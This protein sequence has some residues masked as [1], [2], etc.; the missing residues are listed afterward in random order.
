MFLRHAGVMGGSVA[1]PA[2]DPVVFFRPLG[3][4][5]VHLT[6]IHDGYTLTITAGNQL[7]EYYVFDRPTEASYL[8]VFDGNSAHI[9][10]AAQRPL[11]VIG[12]VTVGNYYDAYRTAYADG[13][14]YSGLV[15]G[16]YAYNVGFVRRGFDSYPVAGGG[17]QCRIRP[18]GILP[19]PNGFF[20]RFTE[21]FTPIFGWSPTNANNFI[22]YE[23]TC[24]VS[25]IDVAGIL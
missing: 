14:T 3:S 4:D 20:V 13:W 8:D 12:S 23:P 21:Q 6:A 5:P 10:T 16:K 24:Q 1:L 9:F 15:G 17:W 18:E 22:S 25:I 19:T 11:N 7:A 2:S